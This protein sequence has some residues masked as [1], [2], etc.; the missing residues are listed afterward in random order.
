M[1]V[2]SNPSLGEGRRILAIARIAARSLIR[3]EGRRVGLVGRRHHRTR[4]GAVA[5]IPLRELVATQSRS[6]QRHALVT[7]HFGARRRNTAH[8]AVGRDALDGELLHRRLLL[9]IRAT[10]RSARATA[11]IGRNAR[12]QDHVVLIHVL[13]NHLTDTGEAER[14]LQLLR[15]LVESRP[16]RSVLL[17]RF[18]RVEPGRRHRL[19]F[20]EPHLLRLLRFRLLAL[21]R[22]RQ[23]GEADLAAA[24]VRREI[25]VRAAAILASDTLDHI[26]WYYSCHNRWLFKG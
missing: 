14:A 10:A 20:L 24:G 5:I 4:V 23:F 16:L 19:P 11:R 9:L 25:V 7:L 22:V 12:Q 13:V 1:K 3:H 17:A 21:I 6:R 2:P 26:N 15:L 8:R 18:V